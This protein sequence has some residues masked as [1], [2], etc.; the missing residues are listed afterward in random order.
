VAGD[1]FVLNLCNFILQN[2]SLGRNPPASLDMN[3]RL[4]VIVVAE[5][6]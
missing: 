3:V 6:F 1:V 2:M 5:K 4:R